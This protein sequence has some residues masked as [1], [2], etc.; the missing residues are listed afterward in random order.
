MGV[1]AIV[2][3]VAAVGAVAGGVGSM[4]N[5]GSGAKASSSAADAQVAA[6]NQAAALQAQE[7]QQTRADLAPWRDT[8]GNA[9]NY[10]GGI[11][12]IPGSTPVDPTNALRSTPGYNW[13]MNQGVDA[14]ERSAAAKGGL[15]ST[16]EQKSLTT[17]GQGLADNTYQSYL[18]KLFQ[19]SGSGL[20]A[21]GM[22]GRAGT[23]YANQAGQD[24]MAAG[25]AQAQG[26]L[27]AYNAQQSGYNSLASGLGAGMSYLNS[28]GVTNYLNSLNP[29][30]YNTNYTA[31]LGGGTPGAGQNYTDYTAAMGAMGYQ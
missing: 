30:G 11:L 7:Y 18:D 3:G 26:T 21:A 22:T 20:T 15:L 16:P 13:A 28:P 5:A 14:R 1:S 10:L 24:Y 31:P 4:M 9:I 27:N 19:V 12:N 17:F 23:N 29:S 6:A 8:G 25:Q 2:G